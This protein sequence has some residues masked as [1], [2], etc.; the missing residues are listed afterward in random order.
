MLKQEAIFLSQLLSGVTKKKVLNIGSMTIPKLRLYQPWCLEYVLEP[1]KKRKNK[2]YNLDM[3]KGEGVDIV[4]DCQDMRQVIRD[5]YFEVVLFLN[6][7]EH[8]L[9]PDQALVEIYRVLAVGGSCFASVPAFDYPYHEDPLDTLLRLSNLED[10]R[11]YF[12]R[13]KWAIVNFKL[14]T[15]SRLQPP[16]LDQVTIIKAIKK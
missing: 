7:L 5:G 9:R 3:E 10:W 1:L 2:I 4:A 12:T 15:D 11:R 8:L 14:V 16:R 6:T 13:E